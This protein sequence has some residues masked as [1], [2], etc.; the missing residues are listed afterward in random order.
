MLKDTYIYKAMVLL[1]DF[2]LLDS[3]LG[4]CVVYFLFIS[5]EHQELHDWDVQSPGIRGNHG[6]RGC[7]LHSGLLS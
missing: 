7:N 5:V 2:L 3:T 6:Y 1:P 4:N